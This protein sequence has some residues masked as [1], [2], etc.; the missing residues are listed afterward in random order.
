MR[1]ISKKVA[2]EGKYQVYVKKIANYGFDNMTNK[3]LT[4]LA[5]TNTPVYIV[6]MAGTPQSGDISYTI[7][8]PNTRIAG[9]PAGLLL[10]APNPT[11]KAPKQAQD[12]AQQSKA[13]AK[14]AA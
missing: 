8:A 3:Q 14:K 12:T 4:S 13:G 7:N 10:T 5:D 9:V 6:D 11:P 2:S 1:M